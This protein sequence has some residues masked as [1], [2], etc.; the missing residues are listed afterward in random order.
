VS[1]LTDRLAPFFVHGS[2]RADP[3]GWICVPVELAALTL[4]LL[5]GVGLASAVRAVKGA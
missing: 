5:A 4:L 3:E 1:S 2:D